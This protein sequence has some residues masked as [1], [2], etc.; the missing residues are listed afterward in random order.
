MNN[1]LFINSLNINFFL[2]QGVII[3]QPFEKTD[4]LRVRITF[5]KSHLMGLLSFLHFLLF[6]K[7]HVGLQ[8]QSIKFTDIGNLLYLL[9]ILPDT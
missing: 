1:E 8:N 6:C 2:C 5:H 3:L 4:V 9:S 7:L